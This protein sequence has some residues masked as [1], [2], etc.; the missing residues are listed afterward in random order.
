MPVYLFLSSP[1]TVYR[2][3]LWSITKS[4]LLIC[5]PYDSPNYSGPPKFQLSC[6]AD[7]SKHNYFYTSTNLLFC[8]HFQPCCMMHSNVAGMPVISLPE[9][10]DLRSP[11]HTNTVRA[12][13]FPLSLALQWNWGWCSWKQ[14]VKSV[15]LA[16][17]LSMLLD[18]CDHLILSC[19]LLPL[20]NLTGLLPTT[21]LSCLGSTTSE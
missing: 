10:F 17:K 21:I 18:Q 19:C 9:M 7:I 20:G 3:E 14:Q 11:W 8:T 16:S 12:V 5:S 6:I 1:D 2:C 15:I 13:P 4:K